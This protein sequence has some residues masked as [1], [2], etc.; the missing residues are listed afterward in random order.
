MCQN[1]IDASNDYSIRCVPILQPKE[2][3]PR[4]SQEDPILGC[5]DT[6]AAADT[7]DITWFGWNVQI[8][9]DLGPCSVAAVALSEFLPHMLDS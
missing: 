2:V 1:I 9:D 6:K 8:L 3:W 4:T 7:N 5:S